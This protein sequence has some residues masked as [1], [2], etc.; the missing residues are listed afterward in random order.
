MLNEYEQEYAGSTTELSSQYFDDDDEL[1]GD[2]VA[3]HAVID[4]VAEGG[5]AGRKACGLGLH[6]EQVGAAGGLT[7]DDADRPVAGGGR[8][9]GG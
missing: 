4:R 8:R 6:G 9:E 7:R 1:E 3:E 2:P 5:V